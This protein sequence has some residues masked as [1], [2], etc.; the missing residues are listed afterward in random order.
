MP[1]NT[2][3]R[4][5]QPSLAK[6]ADP[7]SAAKYRDQGARDFENGKFAEAVVAFS[8]A[9]DLDWTDLRVF[10]DRGNAYLAPNAYTRATKFGVIESLSCANSSTGGQQTNPDP[11]K[12]EPPCYEQPPL[13]F[14]GKDFP[15]LQKG[16]APDKPAPG[17]YDGSKPARP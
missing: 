4:P 10:N 2:T 5:L 3:A 9:I 11:S 1:P 13:L 17:P 12:N 8:E 14:N 6:S 7:Q 16:E 15:L